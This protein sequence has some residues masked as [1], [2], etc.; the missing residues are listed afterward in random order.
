MA[1]PTEEKLGKEVHWEFGSGVGSLLC[2]LKHSRPELSNPTRELN[3]CVAGPMSESMEEMC[4][5]IKWAMDRPN[6]ELRINP[7]VTFNDKGEAFWSPQHHG[8]S[9]VGNFSVQLF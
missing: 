5:V 2:L 8:L 4:H 9:N 3:R 6:I 1:E 7:K